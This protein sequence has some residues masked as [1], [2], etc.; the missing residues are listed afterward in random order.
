M[1]FHQDQMMLTGCLPEQLGSQYNHAICHSLERRYW[2]KVHCN[3]MYIVAHYLKISGNAEAMFPASFR[4]FAAIARLQSNP[5]DGER[6][7]MTG[8]GLHSATLHEANDLPLKYY[9]EC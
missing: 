1:Q 2:Y 3:S 9:V 4:I 7:L 8:H 5:L 6:H